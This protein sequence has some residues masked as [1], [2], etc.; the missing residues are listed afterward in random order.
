MSRREITRIEP[1][2]A[3]RVGFFLGV[4]GGVLFG[5][6]SAALLKSMGDSGAALFGETEAAQLRSLGGV[7]TVFMALF[8]GLIGALLSSLLAGLS[9]IVYNL[10]AHYFGGLE[11]HVEDV[12]DREAA[13]SHS[14]HEND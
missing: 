6:Y 14:S 5:L 3:L 7:S 11:Y 8:M 9:A 12:T 10:A 13:R 2:S 1:R 4:L